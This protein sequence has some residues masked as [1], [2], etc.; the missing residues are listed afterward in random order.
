MKLFSQF[1]RAFVIATGLLLASTANAGLIGKNLTFSLLHPSVP[2]SVVDWASVDID[3]GTKLGSFYVD[4]L[5]AGPKATGILFG[6]EDCCQFAAGTTY[7]I[8]GVDLGMKNVLL[9]KDGSDLPGL[10]QERITFDANTIHVDLGSLK[11]DS[12]FHFWFDIDFG[13]KGEVPGKGPGEVPAEVPE[14]GSVALLGVAAAAL[15]LSRRRRAA[16]R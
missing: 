1:S 12:K 13:D 6:G 2:G 11:L 3:T 14:P 7:R 9:N 8:S 4:Q 5:A 15:A 10:T 16:R